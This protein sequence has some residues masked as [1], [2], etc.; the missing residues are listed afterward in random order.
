MRLRQRCRARLVASSRLITGIAPRCVLLAALFAP[1]A[2]L[3]ATVPSLGQTIPA[4]SAAPNET[5]SV[6]VPVVFS[7]GYDTDP[8][9]GGRPVVLI[10]PALGVPSEVFRE[11]F[12]HVRPAHAGTRPD[13]EQ[14]RQNKAALMNALGRYGVTNERLDTVSNYYRYVRSRGEMWPTRPASAYAVVEK[15]VVT[16][17]VITDG[18]SGYTSPPTITVP[19]IS[20]AAAKIQLSFGKSFDRNGSIAAITVVPQDTGK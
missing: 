16:R 11:A 10:A 17:Y 18:G 4:P 20:V 2:L 12:R 15:G 6:H 13:P 8:R 9:D 5:Q 19:G 1:L 14:V 3:S 7:G